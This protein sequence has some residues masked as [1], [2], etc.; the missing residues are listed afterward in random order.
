M[1]QTTTVDTGQGGAEVRRRALLRLLVAGIAVSMAGGCGLARTKA[2]WWA[3][4]EQNGLKEPGNRLVIGKDREHFLKIM[5]K[6]DKTQAVGDF[7]YWHYR[8]RDGR[9]QMVMQ[10]WFLDSGQVAT[11]SINEF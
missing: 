6:P 10:A 4:L 2:D 8:C 9:I 7:T 5:G 3:L 11:K 1:S